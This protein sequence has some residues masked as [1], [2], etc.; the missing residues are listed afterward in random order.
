MR[1]VKGVPAFDAEEVTINAA[2]VAIIAA[3]DLHT[4]FVAPYAE[5]RL[6]AIATM[7]ADGANV[8]HLPGT[9]LVAVRTRRQ[10]ANRADI[11]AHAAFFTLEVIAFIGRDHR[12]A[13]AILNAQR[14]HVHGFAANPNAAI[15]QDAARPIEV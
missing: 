8:I 4:G 6:A 11:N 5:C 12:S 7:R 1:E 2:L 15:A 3:Y 9:R 13:A 10:G 14:P